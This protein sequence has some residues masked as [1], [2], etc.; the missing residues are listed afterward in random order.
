MAVRLVDWDALDRARARAAA[1]SHYW[2]GWP[3]RSRG[4]QPGSGV[5][6]GPPAITHRGR[7]IAL[8]APEAL[9]GTSA[10][11]EPAPGWQR[12]RLGEGTARSGWDPDEAE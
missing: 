3:G 10:E 5:A 6:G 2:G 9:G 7:H 8:A 4:S 11:W 1:G 12:R